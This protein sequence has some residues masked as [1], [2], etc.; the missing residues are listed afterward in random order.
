[1]ER[2]GSEQETAVLPGNSPEADAA[3]EASGTV[4]AGDAA[5]PL[6]VQQARQAL[7]QAQ[8]VLQS[9]LDEYD[10]IELEVDAMDVYVSEIE[11]RGED[12]LDHQAEIM[13]RFKPLLDEYL[14]AEA[15]MNEAI[16]AEE[17]A[18][19]NLAAALAAWSGEGC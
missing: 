16:A 7:A 3:P 13:E 1:M 2:S 10:R 4:E 17:A 8:R 15:R 19:A 12:P 11:A 14:D 6:P 18:A 9:V 5:E